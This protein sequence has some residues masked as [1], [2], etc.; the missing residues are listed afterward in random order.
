[1]SKDIGRSVAGVSTG[2]EEPVVVGTITNIEIV[3]TTATTTGQ[4]SAI[5]SAF[6]AT[7]SVAQVSAHSA[8][9][10][11][12]AVQQPMVQGGY[13]DDGDDDDESDDDGSGDDD[14]VLDKDEDNDDED[15]FDSSDELHDGSGDDNDE[16]GGDDATGGNK[17]SQQGSPDE[18]Q[19]TRDADAAVEVEIA[20]IFNVS[21]FIP[22]FVMN[23]KWCPLLNLKL[24][25]LLLTLLKFHKRQRENGRS[26][27]SSAKEQV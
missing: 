14:D 15:M 11:V 19:R 22:R 25:L 16:I 21:S 3:A 23:L 1:M 18:A 7:T 26:L 10:I 13:S 5:T 24:L 9:V 4:V 20:F 8:S 27:T 6:I 17:A 2:V 12:P